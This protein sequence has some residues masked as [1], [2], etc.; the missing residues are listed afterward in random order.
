MLGWLKKLFED[1]ALPEPV[2]PPATAEEALARWRKASRPAEQVT[3]LEGL[4]AVGGSEG[5][6]ILQSVLKTGASPH[7]RIAAARLLGESGQK[8]NAFLLGE[9][10]KSDAEPLVRTACENALA[11]LRKS[12]GG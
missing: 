3:A 11:N 9:A 5:W 10:A 4:A 12:A 1:P 6:L 7:T 8:G 2:P